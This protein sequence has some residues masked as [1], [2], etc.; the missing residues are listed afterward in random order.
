MKIYWKFANNRNEADILL[1]NEIEKKKPFFTKFDIFTLLFSSRTAFFESGRKKTDN[2][3]QNNWIIEIHN[4]FVIM[5][6]WFLSLHRFL[7]Q[8]LLN[9][10]EIKKWRISKSAV[11]LWPRDTPQVRLGQRWGRLINFLFYSQFQ[12][13]SNSSNF[14]DFVLWNFFSQLSNWANF[15][16]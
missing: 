9:N 13:L 1:I 7:W 8:Q 14:F 4:S 16:H 2:F 5:R 12:K 15:H 6:T 11:D 3:W 10:L